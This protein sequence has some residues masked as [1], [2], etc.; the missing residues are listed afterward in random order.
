MPRKRRLSDWVYVK[1]SPIH[2]FGCF[3]LRRIRKGTHIGSYEGPK[4]MEDD[5]YVLWILEDEEADYWEGVD[6]QNELRYMNHSSTPNAEFDGVDCYALRT[7]E[8]NEE[9]TFH[10]GD[11]WEDVP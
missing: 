8:E 3:A 10:Y 6:G 7:I 1:D 9:I 5:T 2:G 11:E 4:T